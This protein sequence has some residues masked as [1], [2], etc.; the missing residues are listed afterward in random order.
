M[1]T[2]TL[3]L[4][5]LIRLVDDLRGEGFGVGMRQYVDAQRLLISL[6]AHGRHPRHPLDL[7]THLAP[8]LCSTPKEQEK[9][10]TFFPQWLSGQS[11]LAQDSDRLSQLDPGAGTK[12]LGGKRRRWLTARSLLFVGGVVAL[13]LAYPFAIWLDGALSRSISGVVV[14]QD[15]HA[16]VAGAIVAF[17]TR[18]DGDGPVHD[19]AVTD[20]GGNFTFTYRV[21][22]TPAAL[23]VTHEEYEAKTHPLDATG[24]AGPVVVT[25]TRAGPKPTPPSGSGQGGQAINDSPATPAQTPQLTPA[26]ETAASNAR[27][28]HR[29]LQLAALLLPLLIFAA[30]WLRRF[31]GRRRMLLRRARTA[32]P[33]RLEHLTVKGVAEQLFQGQSFR[34]VV[35]ELRRHRP[36]ISRDIDE[37]NTIEATVRRGGLFTPVYG[38]RRTLP[39]YLVLI[40]RMG[41]SDQLARFQEELVSRLAQDSLNIDTYYFR[42]DPRICRRKVEYAAHPPNYLTLPDLAALHPDYYLLIFGDGASFTDPVTGKPERWLE[43]FSPW[44]GRAIMTPEAPAFWRFREWTLRESDFLILPTGR[45]GLAALGEAV[46]AGTP[47]ALDG[48]QTRKLRR[49]PELLRGWP[50]RWLEDHEPPPEQVERLVEQLETYLGPDGMNWLAASAVYPALSWD[51]TLY[52]GFE[53]FPHDEEFEQTLLSLV[54]LP[55]LRHGIMPDWLRTA[56]VSSLAPPDERAVRHALENLLIT[57][58]DAPPD[59]VRLDYSTRSLE[60]VARGRREP[61]RGPREWARAWRRR[62]TLRELFGVAH[63]ES[64]LHDYVFLTF[65]SGRRPRRIDLNVPDVLRRILFPGGFEAFGPRPAAL[66]ACALLLSLVGWAAVGSLEPEGRTQ[67]PAPTMTAPRPAPTPAPARES[68]SLKPAALI[69]DDWPSLRFNFSIERDGPTSGGAAPLKKLRASDVSVTLDERLVTVTESDLRLSETAPARILILLDDTG[70]MRLGVDKFSAAKRAI[71]A[72]IDGLGPDDV[73]SFATF[74]DSIKIVVEPTNNRALLHA[75]VNNLVPRASPDTRLYDAVEYGVRQAQLNDLH[76]IVIISDGWEDSPETQRLGETALADYKRE[77]ERSITKRAREVGVR[78]FTI[79]VGDERGA[80]LDHVDRVS[81]SNISG[82]TNGG[83]AVYIDLPELAARAGGNRARYQEILSDRLSQSLESL[84]QPFYQSYALILRL[85]QMAQRDGKLHTL[86]I[87]VSVGDDSTRV[88]LPLEYIFEWGAGDTPQFRS[89]GRLYT[90]FFEVMS[91]AFTRAQLAT[92]YVSGLAALVALALFPLLMQLTAG[93]GRTLLVKTQTARSRRGSGGA[94]ES[95]TWLFT[96]RP[97]VLATLLLATVWLGG[98]LLQKW[99]EVVPTPVELGPVLQGSPESRTP[100]PPG[101]VYVPGG[102]FLMGR[103]NGDEYERPAHTVTLKP[104]Y[105]DAYEVTCEQYQVFIQATSYAAPRGWLSGNY[106]GGSARKPVTGIS[107][108]DAK[109]YADWANKRL[110]TEEEWEYAARGT[111][112]R[113]YP[114]GNEWKSGMANAASASGGLADVGSYGGASP[115][116]AYDMAGNAWEWTASTLQAYPGGRLPIQDRQ[117]LRVIRGGNWQSARGAATTTYRGAWPAINADYSNCGFR[118]VK[119]IE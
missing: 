53:L 13:L 36:R 95:R 11:H 7:C 41:P 105:I 40:D 119:D 116:G 93:A 61:R 50:R 9:F 6:A 3:G 68:Y 58:L 82:A 4:E 33:P 88:V 62:T 99:R 111:D 89:P 64:P 31:Y 12:P 32:R 5:D 84:R 46:N 34:R 77:R 91:G 57:A 83:V 47:D 102:A 90:P 1:T 67:L 112:G 81:L 63:E 22:H 106:P 17:R 87:V 37:Q 72:F 98:S 21:W 110:P 20:E 24:S 92:I 74:G 25:L 28:F 107:W 114:W 104:F 30:W 15:D 42:G 78:I 71:L 113:L 45:E 18:A 19:S 51:I 65:L 97:Y 117:D 108:E 35:Q 26:S 79:A 54:S 94:K 85:G 23:A 29:R 10:Y 80:G 52:L 55:W 75:A 38:S 44:T 103:D 8:V 86:R 48:Q 101:M 69:S 109:A 96:G 2:Q 118:L 27:A 60:P 49:F 73:V 100:T 70:S 43:Q 56:L 115:F 39:E 66:L 14:R 59:G 76:N 16:A